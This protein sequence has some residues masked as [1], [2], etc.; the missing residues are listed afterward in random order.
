MLSGGNQRRVLP[1]HCVL[2]QDDSRPEQRKMKIL[3]IPF[4][5]VEIEPKTVAFTITRLCLWAPLAS[6]YLDI[7]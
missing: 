6:N 7:N 2:T 4:P 1:L 3:D 5:R